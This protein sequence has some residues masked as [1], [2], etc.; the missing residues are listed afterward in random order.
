M[1]SRPAA[2]PSA[3][4]QHVCPPRGG[5]GAAAATPISPG[6][7]SLSLEGHKQTLTGQQE[8]TRLCL[9]VI[10]KVTVRAAPQKG[11]GPAWILW[12]LKKSLVAPLLW[13]EIREKCVVC[14]LESLRTGQTIVG[15]GS[16]YFVLF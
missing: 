1:P 4:A 3:T 9:W 13:G 7:S 10:V 12:H 2:C 5:S 15:V 16:I 6:L 11:S 14:L 8:V